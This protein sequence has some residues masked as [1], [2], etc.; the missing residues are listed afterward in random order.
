LA[1]GLFL[2]V[3]EQGL[4]IRVSAGMQMH[5]RDVW[6]ELPFEMKLMLLHVRRAEKGPAMLRGNLPEPIV[7]AAQPMVIYPIAHRRVS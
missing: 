7:P 3:A 2:P 5:L 1:S 4:Q 6:S